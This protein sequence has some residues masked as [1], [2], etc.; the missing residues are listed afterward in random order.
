MNYKDYP[1][2]FEFLIIPGVRF[3]VAGRYEVR[4]NHEEGKKQQQSYKNVTFFWNRETS[5][6]CLTFLHQRQTQAHLRAG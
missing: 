4:K 3:I 1:L 5:L 2:R 6:E